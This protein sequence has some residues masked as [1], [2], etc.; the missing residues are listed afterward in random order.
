VSLL[1][2][3]FVRGERTFT[4]VLGFICLLGE[5]LYGF[6]PPEMFGQFLS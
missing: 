5:A 3:G 1:G 6:Y 2:I 4:V